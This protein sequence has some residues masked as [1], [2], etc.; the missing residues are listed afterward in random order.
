MRQRASART[1]STVVLVLIVGLSLFPAQARGL[2]LPRSPY[3]GSVRPA[4]AQGPVSSPG[5]GAT[6]SPT[7]TTTVSAP[8]ALSA[9]TVASPTE[10]ASPTAATSPTPSPIATGTSSATASATA[11]RQFNAA[12]PPPPGGVPS[13]AQRRR[14]TSLFSGSGLGPVAPGAFTT[15]PIAAGSEPGAIVA[16]PDGELWLSEYATSKLAHGTTAGVL[17]ACALPSSSSEPGG[18]TV[19]QDGNLWVPEE[20]TNNLLRSTTGCAFQETGTPTAGSAPIWAA[21]DRTGRSG[22]SRWTGTRSGG[23]P[24][25]A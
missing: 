2:A 22:S 4:D 3:G 8:A 7:A 20:G 21:R 5:A 10:T 19:G 24:P 12:L 25:P 13:L 23:P 14:L 17:T 9:T 1:V 18:L 6:P 15:Y 11:D 16:G